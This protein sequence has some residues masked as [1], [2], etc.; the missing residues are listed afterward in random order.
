MHWV[1]VLIKNI[2]CFFVG[3]LLLNAE[4]NIF[5]S[6]F[7]VAFCFA[8]FYV[9][10][11]FLNYIFGTTLASLLY[12]FSLCSV[13]STFSLILTLLGL[14]LLNKKIKKSIVLL[15]V[16]VVI[17]SVVKFFFNLTSA[18]ALVLGVINLV[19]E[20]AFC[21]A[22][23]MFFRAIKIRGTNTKF[24]MDEVLGFALI[25]A[26]IV[27]SVSKI[28][29]WNFNLSQFFV[30]LILF[31]ISRLYGGTETLA[32]AIIC[33]IGMSFKDLEL[34]YVAVFSIEAI[35]LIATKRMG[36]IS[37]VIS[38]VLLDL[39]MGYFFL[40]YPNFSISQLLPTLL[41]GLIY[42]VIRKKHWM[43]MSLYVY[44][45]YEEVCLNEVVIQ[46]EKVLKEK[47]KRVSGL[48]REMHGIYKHMVI[49][50]LDQSQVEEMIRSDL[51]RENCL[52]CSKYKNCYEGRGVASRS[53]SELVKRGINKK[54][55]TLVDIPTMLA[56]VCGKT[57]HMIFQLN[58]RLDEYFS[59]EKELEEED[60]GKILISNQLLGVSELIDEFG[61]DFDFGSRAPI[62]QEQSLID[63]FLY[64]DIIIKECAVFYNELCFKRAVLVVK[65][66]KYNRNEF[67]KVLNLFFKVKTKILDVKFA[68]VSGWQVVS[69]VPASKYTYR[70]GVAK[71]SKE[72]TSGDKFSELNIDDKK[73]VFVISDGKGCGDNASKISEMTINLIENFYKSGFKTEHIMENVNKVMS[74]KSGESFSAVDVCVLDLDL[75][76]VDFVKRGGTPS[77]IKKSSHALVV[78]GDSLPIGMME[79]S[80]STIENR[81]VN[82]GDVI[83]L[84]SDGV[85]DA[86]NS[87]E[88]FA[89]FIN[90]IPAV[91]VQEFANN[92]LNKAIMLNKGHILDDMTVLAIKVILNR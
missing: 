73:A 48:F 8:L 26:P 47:L 12:K 18:Q 64:Y 85:F 72:R 87:S 28:E 20:I 15:L 66:K 91:N 53:I 3:F 6:P 70:V 80:K 27:L 38:L 31:V 83:V 81:Y 61:T 14:K 51:V 11:N 23:V 54:T 68:K 92:I 67:E 21:Y 42:A 29:L 22:Y 17:S 59:Y 10:S 37:Q 84:A 25:V 60:D 40:I 52:H 5:V 74:Y 43:K 7:F 33:G 71:T 4:V 75:A 45:K 36:R 82:S 9:D 79:N 41:A 55:V 44:N 62:E 89:G 32:I 16:C 49:G 1:R 30:P 78:E 86:F 69:V 65:N 50:K 2:V 77:V 56:S 34:V 57:N 39:I 19:L 46:E 90:N 13:L 76:R 24:A 58:N 63:S 88:N 35:A